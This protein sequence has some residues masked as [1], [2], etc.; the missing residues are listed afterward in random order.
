MRKRYPNVSVVV[1]TLN[2]QDALRRTVNGL[3][4]IDYPGGFE[5]IVVNDG[6]TDGTKEM[7]DRTFSKR[8]KIKIIHIPHSG[9]C[10]ARNIGIENSHG[11]IIVNMDHD[12]IPAKDWLRQLIR[13]FDSETIGI[14]SSYG[15]YG[16][17]STA[18]R[19]E[20][21]EKVGGYD[22][23]YG[24]YREDTDLSFKIMA[25]GYEFR[26]VAADYIHD[27]SPVSPK[28][29][30]SA[31]K[32][33]LQRWK[34]HMNDVLLF[35]KHPQLAKD[36]LNVKMGFL[37]NPLTDFKVATGLWDGKY[38]ASS[39]RG[40]TFIKNKSPVHSLAIFLT[41]LLYVAGVKSY[42][43]RGSLKFGKLLV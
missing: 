2:N 3:L 22:E 30:A 29:V 6:S 28:G 38:E 36:F 11:S 19:K 40:I 24:Y 35:K 13:G 17:T 32:Y 33:A 43:L 20:L 14:V 34:Y 16:G 21:L 7:L 27:H 18:F 1:A 23:A 5:I 4:N 10:V 37:I 42:R 31:L 9:V 15:Y 39:P 12:C 26:L 8:K 25:L 41:G